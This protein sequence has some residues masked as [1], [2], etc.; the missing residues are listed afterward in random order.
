MIWKTHTSQAGRR[1]AA[2]HLVHYLYSKAPVQFFV[3]LF[4][5]LGIHHG[6]EKVHARC[7]FHIKQGEVHA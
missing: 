3:P 2:A 5:T 1:S 4:I 6:V 7:L